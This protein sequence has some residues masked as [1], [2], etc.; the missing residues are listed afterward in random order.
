MLP[1]VPVVSFNTIIN[2]MD[3]FAGFTQMIGSQLDEFNLLN[4]ISVIASI[5][6]SFIAF[7]GINFPTF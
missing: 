5:I 3:H 2:L 7:M 1:E 6:N 4:P